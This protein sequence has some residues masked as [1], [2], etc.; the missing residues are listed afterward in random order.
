MMA[1]ARRSD[2][3]TR[4]GPG[5]QA[6]RAVETRFRVTSLPL[7]QSASR[8]AGKWST[9][10]CPGSAAKGNPGI[11]EGMMRRLFHPAVL[12]VFAAGCASAQPPAACPIPGEMLHWRADYCM[13][14]IG[15]DD[16]IAAG[17]CLEREAHIALGDPCEAKFHYK[18]GMCGLSVDNG[19]YPG[20]V[21]ECVDDPL[22]IGLVVRNGGA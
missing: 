15:T 11:P 21:G 8:D 1:W 4:Q 6:L 18:R 12:A 19:A 9:L 16:V 5:W 3:R 10:L 14:R 17:E 13:A 7:L 2:A 22:Y 20:T